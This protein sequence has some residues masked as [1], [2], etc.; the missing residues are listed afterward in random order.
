M[1][2]ILNNQKCIARVKMK[3]E[4]GIYNSFNKTGFISIV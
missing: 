1:R 2:G 3:N 4:I